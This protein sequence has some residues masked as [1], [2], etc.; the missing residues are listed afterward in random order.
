MSD[1]SVYVVTEI[2]VVKD[3]AALRVYAT[4]SRLQVEERGGNVVAKGG[5]DFHDGSAS[6]FIVHKW[7]DVQTFE[8]WQASDEYRPL[9]ETRQRSAEV[10]MT[11]VPAAT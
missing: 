9:K 1:S 5:T 7:P 6:L 10:R 4:A 3:A 8:N 11:I 2:L